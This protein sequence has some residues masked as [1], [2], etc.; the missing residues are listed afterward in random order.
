MNRIMK[1]FWWAFA[2]EM[3]AEKYTIK[4]KENRWDFFWQYAGKKYGTFVEITEGTKIS[5]AWLNQK[6]VENA[7]EVSA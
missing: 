6:A 5:T 4:R 3:H 7:V 2:G 1:E